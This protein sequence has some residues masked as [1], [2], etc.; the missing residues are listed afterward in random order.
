M[1]TLL[2]EF[3][4]YYFNTKLIR[5]I[6]AD[7]ARHY[8]SVHQ[9]IPKYL[10]EYIVEQEAA[11]KQSNIIT[12][13]FTTATPSSSNSSKSSEVK[14]PGITDG[15]RTYS[16][17]L[18]KADL[19]QIISTAITQQSQTG[20]NF[21]VVTINPIGLHPPPLPPPEPN[22]EESATLSFVEQVIRH[23]TKIDA[24]GMVSQPSPLPDFTSSHHCF[25]CPAW[26]QSDEELNEHMSQH[27][28]APLATDQQHSDRL[29]KSSEKL[30]IAFM[31]DLEA[32]LLGKGDSSVHVSVQDKLFQSNPLPNLPILKQVKNYVVFCSP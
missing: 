31:D 3:I 14:I 8:G 1:I 13:A 19:N 26:F 17:F 9:F 2:N 6:L 16:A 15:E 11:Q 28:S 7:W 12:K 25:L 10:K 30:D 4:N 5:S 20:K 23:S 24:S 27:A 22:L 18:P 29:N 32:S 21:G